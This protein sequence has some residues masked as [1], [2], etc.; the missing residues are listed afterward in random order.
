MA[1]PFYNLENNLTDRTI[2]LTPAFLW[3]IILG[4]LKVNHNYFV[5]DL[6]G[7]GY[8]DIAAPRSDQREVWILSAFTSPFTSTL[9]YKVT[10]PKEYYLGQNYPN[11]FNPSTTIAFEIPKLCR[12]TIKIYDILG[13]EIRTL[14]DECFNQGSYSVTNGLKTCQNQRNKILPG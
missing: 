1:I 6:D 9:H 7:D 2:D 13:G 12:V 14:I 11:P 8:Q 5:T 4:G 10:T 3:A